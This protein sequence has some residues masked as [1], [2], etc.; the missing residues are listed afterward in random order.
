MVLVVKP[1]KN[2]KPLP[3]NPLSSGGSGLPI[4]SGALRLVVPS[5]NVNWLRVAVPVLLRR[6]QPDTLSLRR[7]DAHQHELP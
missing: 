1:G 7:A 3:I 6:I 2:S 5:V 4:V